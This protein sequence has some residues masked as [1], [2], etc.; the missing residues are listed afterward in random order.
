ML[1]R[2]HRW[3]IGDEHG[4]AKTTSKRG[5]GRSAHGDL[6]RVHAVVVHRLVEVV[7]LVMLG[8][9]HSGRHRRC[10]VLELKRV[11]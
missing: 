5:M 11:Q 4:E 9:L 3:S 7:L 8:V 2:E 6:I 1:G 10:M